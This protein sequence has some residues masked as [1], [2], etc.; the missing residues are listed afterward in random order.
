MNLI[1][2]CFFLMIRRPPRST[3]TDTLFPYT[4][5]FRSLGLP[6]CSRN[7]IPGD[8]ALTGVTARLY[9]T[10]KAEG[11]P[12]PDH[13][14]G[15]GVGAVEEN[16]RLHLQVFRIGDIVLASCACEPQS[17]L[18]LNLDSDRKSTRLNSSH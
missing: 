2:F 12:V 7:G 8:N 15:P 6:D 3:R 16:L 18:I 11:V 14:S 9:A 5:R 10:L 4:T 1:I 13:Y 17:D